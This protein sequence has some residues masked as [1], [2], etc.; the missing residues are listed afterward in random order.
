VC[1]E[2]QRHVVSDECAPPLCGVRLTVDCEFDRLRD[3]AIK[4]RVI[5]TQTGPTDMISTIIRLVARMEQRIQDLQ[6]KVETQ[7]MA[8]LNANP[9]KDFLHR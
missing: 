6:E 1:I 4:N 9:P 7:R 8:A 3:W 5:D 2:G